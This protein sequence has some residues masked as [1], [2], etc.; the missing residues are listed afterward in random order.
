MDLRITSQDLRIRLTP[1]APIKTVVSSS[2]IPPPSF[3]LHWA[4]CRDIEKYQLLGR[5]I[6][7]LHNNFVVE[8]YGRNPNTKAS[9]ILPVP[10]GLMMYCMSGSNWSQCV[11]RI[12]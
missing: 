9:W 4:M 11:T 2:Q 3:S 10:P 6:H 12:I 1:T 8:T 7:S 5:E